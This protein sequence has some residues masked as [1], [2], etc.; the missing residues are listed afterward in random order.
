MASL[1]WMIAALAAGQVTAPPRP[2]CGVGRLVMVNVEAPPGGSAALVLLDAEGKPLA[3]PRP[4]EPGPCDLGALLPEIWSLPR[5]AWVQ[6]LAGETP[7]GPALV[8]EP[9]LSRQ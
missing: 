1:A 3:P 5:A 7:V 6:C 8:V 4:V 9:L 2:Y